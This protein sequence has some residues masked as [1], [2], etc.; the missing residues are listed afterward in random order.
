MGLALM[1]YVIPREPLASASRAELVD[2]IAPTIQRY[3]T[4]EIRSRSKSSK[5]AT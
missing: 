4:G 2:L 3:L 5:D 1:R